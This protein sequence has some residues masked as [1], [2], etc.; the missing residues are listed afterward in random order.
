MLRNRLDWISS[1][2][3]NLFK[4]NYESTAGQSKFWKYEHSAEVKFN[5]HVNISAV[6]SGTVLVPPMQLSFDKLLIPCQHQDVKCKY[7]SS[8][9]W[10]R[11]GMF[12]RPISRV[13]EGKALK[14]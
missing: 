8:R 5:C 1:E 7:V 12:Y 6:I 2:P 10:G 14:N 9:E 4:S 3:E 11:A 13:K